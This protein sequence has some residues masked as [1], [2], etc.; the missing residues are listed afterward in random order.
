MGGASRAAIRGPGNAAMRGQVAGQT[1]GQGGGAGFCYC[2]AEPG[3]SL[4]KQ[5]RLSAGRGS[6]GS[7]NQAGQQVVRRNLNIQPTHRIV[8]SNALRVP[9]CLRKGTRSSC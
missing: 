6:T 3:S 2:R 7:L 5:S 8:V 4:S 9:A 1:T